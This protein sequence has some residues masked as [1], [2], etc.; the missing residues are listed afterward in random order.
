MAHA[1]PAKNKEHGKCLHLA[2]IRGLTHSLNNI[3]VFSG[4]A[5]TLVA[6]DRK[7]PS[8]PTSLAHDKNKSRRFLYG[9]KVLLR[10]NDSPCNGGLNI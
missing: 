8:R 5:Y 4:K 6:N 3:M 9:E 2:R 7:G 1:A 10:G